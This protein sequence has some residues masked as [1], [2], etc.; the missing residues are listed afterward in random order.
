[1]IT[2]CVLI[3]AVLIVARLKRKCKGDRSM[4]TRMET[5]HSKPISTLKMIRKNSLI[6]ERVFYKYWI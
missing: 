5:R 2:L 6:L 3:L 1:M 4:T